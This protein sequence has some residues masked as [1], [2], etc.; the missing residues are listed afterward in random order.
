MSL[1]LNY[2]LYFLHKLQNCMFLNSFCIYS[3]LWLNLLLFPRMPHPIPHPIPQPIPHPILKPFLPR[4][5]H[6]YFDFINVFTISHTLMVCSKWSFSSLLVSICT[7]VKHTKKRVETK[8]RIWERTCGLCLL[9]RMQPYTAVQLFS[10]L[11][12]CG[13]YDSFSFTAWYF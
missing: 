4:I 2:Q 13:F 1:L 6:L 7:Q 10:F 5:L 3:L 8:I 12:I 9:K 11:S